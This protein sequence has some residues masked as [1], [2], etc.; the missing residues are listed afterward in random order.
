MNVLM[1]QKHTNVCVS[2]MNHSVTSHIFDLVAGG[3]KKKVNS[4][5]GDTVLLLSYLLLSPPCQ[6]D[7]LPGGFSVFWGPV[8]PGGDSG[9]ERHHVCRAPQREHSGTVAKYFKLHHPERQPT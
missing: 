6:A 4:E 8:Q 9:C 2:L 3:A 5:P 7:L 1:I